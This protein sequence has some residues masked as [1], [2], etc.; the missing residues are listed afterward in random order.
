MAGLIVGLAFG[1]E[2]PASSTLLARLA[3]SEQR[4]LIFSVRQTGNQIGAMAGSLTPAIALAAPRAGF[5]VIAGLALVAACI[6]LSL[7][8]R[9]IPSL[10]GPS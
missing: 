7:R 4:P 10:A 1:P 5:A 6:F 2:T 3:R 9:T 8:A